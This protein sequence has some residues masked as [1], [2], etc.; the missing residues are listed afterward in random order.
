[1]TVEYQVIQDCPQ[2]VVGTD[3]TVWRWLRRRKRWRQLKPV[4]QPKGYLRVSLSDGPKRVYPK[5]VHRLVL[6]AFV[7]A[8]PD[9]YEARHLDGDPANNSLTNLKWG[10]STENQEDRRTHGTL[11]K[12]DSHFRSLLT[13]AQRSD[14]LK[15]LGEGVRQCDL[16]KKYR[17]R[18][19]VIQYLASTQSI[20]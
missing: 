13:E 5:F 10:T 12:G 18:K 17:V 4:Q 1:M 6:K 20:A 2:Y 7:G 8:A 19:G 11:P 16:A 3:G 15:E 9:G 14:V